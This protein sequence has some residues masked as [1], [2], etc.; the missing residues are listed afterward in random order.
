MLQDLPKFHSGDS[1]TCTCLAGRMHDI[2]WI[3]E[4]VDLF[5]KILSS[6]TVLLYMPAR[7]LNSQVL[8]SCESIS[9]DPS[10]FYTYLE[11]RMHDIVTV[12]ICAKL[13]TRS[14]HY[15]YSCM[16]GRMPDVVVICEGVNLFGKIFPSFTYVPGRMHAIFRICDVVNISSIVSQCWMDA[17]YYSLLLRT[18]TYTIA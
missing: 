8:W 14:S 17:W 7:M 9:Q 10:K 16:L 2:V 11:A 12:G 3:C 18:L 13:W 4:V 1:Y 6:F 5:L 15:F